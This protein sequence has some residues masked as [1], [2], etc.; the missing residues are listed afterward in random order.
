[1]YKWSF[2]NCWTTDYKCQLCEQNIRNLDEVL[3]KYIDPKLALKY[4]KSDF[5][6]VFHKYSEIKARRGVARDSSKDP[7]S[8][9]TLEAIVGLF[10]E[11]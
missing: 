9:A 3:Y 1:M 5:I 10:E 7:T 11:N 2:C 8:D 6:E 4:R